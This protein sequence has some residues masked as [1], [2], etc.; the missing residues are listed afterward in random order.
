MRNQS[1][2]EKKE[3]MEN[4]TNFPFG[5]INHHGESLLKNDNFF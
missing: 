5:D 1:I 2:F 3:N 4:Y